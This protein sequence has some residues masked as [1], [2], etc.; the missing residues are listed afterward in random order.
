MAST[1]ARQL[2]MSTSSKGAVAAAAAA[3]VVTITT[4]IMTFNNYNHGDIDT[5][6]NHQQNLTKIWNHQYSLSWGTKTMCEQEHKL[7][8]RNDF[9]KTNNRRNK[10]ND[11]ILSSTL[12]LGA[13]KSQRAT[14]LRTR[15][16]SI[17]R[18]SL[19]SE[20]S[21]N[22]SVPTFFVALSGKSDDQEIS[23]SDSSDGGMSVDE[24]KNLWYDRGMHIKH[25]RFHSYIPSNE[26]GFFEHLVDKHLSDHVFEKSHYSVP[27]KELQ[28]RMEQFLTKPLKI[29]DKLWECQI[30][31]GPLGSS[32]TLSNNTNDTK[33][34]KIES[35]QKERAEEQETVVLFRSHHCI[36]DGVSLGAALAD[37]ADE[38]KELQDMIVAQMRDYRRKNK[39]KNLLDKIK[40]FLMKFCWLFFGSIQSVFYQIYLSLVSSNPF[41]FLLKDEEDLENA[42]A[43]RNVSWCDAAPVKEAQ[44]VA[45]KL[46]K[47]A[48]IND[49]FVTCISRAIQ[50]QLNQHHLKISPSPQKTDKINIVVPVHLTGGI[51]LPGTSMGNRI[52]AFVAR[53]PLDSDSSSDSSLPLQK[54]LMN[55]SQT[56]G[57]LKRSP[58]PLISYFM[59]KAASDY[60]PVS[61]TQHLFRN[62]NQNAVVVVSNVR[63]PEKELH[64]NGRSIKKM[65]GFV[66]LPPG[67]PIGITVFSYSGM[68]GLAVN[69]DKRVV[70]DADLFLSWVLEEYIK[71]C[72][73]A[74]AVS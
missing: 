46:Y 31:S 18:F 63:G 36:A 47:K 29:N 52:G 72:H 44:Q 10:N 3:S 50:K 15:M 30:S 34:N 32:G 53:V 67:I 43:K 12:P 28:A 56:L 24:F 62:A 2:L 45:K 21:M 54:H 41:D 38:A 4:T 70:P 39:P 25:P 16:T 71:L 17:G 26:N 73:E 1:A 7:H 51:L 33:N 35:E 22:P 42:E 64:W 40:K 5:L 74:N 19:R 69:A 66:P 65:G 23:S 60:L 57:F 59:A 6:N 58:T 49:V 27:K 9:W 68:V 13:E 8:S 11:T 14:N 20:T 61:I 48:T 55:V 37:L